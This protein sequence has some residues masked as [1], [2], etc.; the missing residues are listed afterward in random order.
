[1]LNGSIGEYTPKNL[2]EK[3]KFSFFTEK[4]FTVPEWF[5]II[6]NGF[7]QLYFGGKRLGIKTY[8]HLII[9]LNYEATKE[10]GQNLLFYEGIKMCNEL[11]VEIREVVR[12][13]R[14]N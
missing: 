3:C 9:L 1:M 6:Y 11:L 13:S 5:H 7:N 8:A 2:R 10:C 12:S 4:N 14:E